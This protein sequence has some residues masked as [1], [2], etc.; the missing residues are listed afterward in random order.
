MWSERRANDIGLDC[1]F[2]CPSSFRCHLMMLHRKLLGEFHAICAIDLTTALGCSSVIIYVTPFLTVRFCCL[3][4]V[5]PVRLVASVC[6]SSSRSSRLLLRRITIGI[7]INRHHRRLS[8]PPQPP[9][10]P[11]H[12]HPSAH[13]PPPDPLTPAPHHPAASPPPLSH[14]RP[15]HTPTGAAI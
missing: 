6:V 15:A 4:N 1:S 5:F 11:P 8:P 2:R 3:R 13:T 9:P 12:S 7:A 14:T 10:P